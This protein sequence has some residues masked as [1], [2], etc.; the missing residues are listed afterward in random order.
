VNSNPIEGMSN[1]EIDVALRALG[2][3]GGWVAY[4]LA[5][6][7]HACEVAQDQAMRN[8]NEVQRLR[9]ELEAYKA[10]PPLLVDGE[11]G[12][13]TPLLD[14]RR[15]RMIKSQQELFNK[16][17]DLV[18]KVPP[19]FDLGPTIELVRHAWGMGWD[20]IRAGERIFVDDG[21]AQSTQSPDARAMQNMAPRGSR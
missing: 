19:E 11:T 4:Y 20:V 10:H 21:S 1:A 2:P 7:E 18:G 12:K 16:A 13:I 6:K 8:G 3:V 9:Q 15:I 14:E 5:Q 17:L